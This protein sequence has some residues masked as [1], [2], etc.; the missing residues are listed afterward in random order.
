M[1]D[2]MGHRAS[3]ATIMI[4]DDHKSIRDLVRLVFELDGFTVV[5]EAADGREAVTLGEK[6]HPDVVILDYEMPHQDGEA[7]AA[8]L[9]ERCPEARIVAFSGV[10]ESK[11]D[12]A[13]AYLRKTDVEELTDVVITLP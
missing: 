8:G 10:L 4:V 13:D 5:G 6:L 2:G 11:P 1:G 9:R 7:T 12:W 3:E